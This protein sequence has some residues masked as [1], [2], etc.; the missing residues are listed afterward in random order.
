VATWI[1][2][3]SGACLIR[4]YASIPDQALDFWRGALDAARELNG[5]EDGYVY[6]AEPTPFL[7]VSRDEAV[8]PAYFWAVFKYTADG[9]CAGVQTLSNAPPS[10][11]PVNERDTFTV[12][13]P[14]VGQLL[15]DR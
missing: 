7:H 9:E 3:M 6:S 5:L 11:S 4:D 8:E 15:G 10:M 12:Y 13:T 14:D 2:D 1:E